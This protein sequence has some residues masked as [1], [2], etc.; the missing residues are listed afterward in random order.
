MKFSVSPTHQ[1]QLPDDIW[2]VCPTVLSQTKAAFNN[3]HYTAYVFIIVLL[4][5][6]IFGTF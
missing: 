4:T 1:Y 5:L 3:V 2:H 6:I